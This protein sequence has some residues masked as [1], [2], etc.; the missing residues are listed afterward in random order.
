MKRQTGPQ[1]ASADNEQL[2]IRG[3]G[4]SG[5]GTV[6]QG[7][8]GTAPWLVKEQGTPNLLTGQVT[9][10]ATSTV[11]AAARAT[12]RAITVVNHGTTDV[13]IGLAGVATT[14]GVLLKGIAGG[15]ITFETTVAIN[16]IVGA[17][18]QVISFAE[19]YD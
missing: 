3:G 12:R 16:G 19:E 17:G 7:P 18:T 6:T 10:A 2:E 5:G 15:G 4:G 8:A 13:F 14:T 11:I 9:I 1:D